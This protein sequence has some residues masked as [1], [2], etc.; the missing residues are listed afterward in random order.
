MSSAH[1]PPLPLHQA[2]FFFINYFGIL[3]SS[4]SIKKSFPMQN[5]TLFPLMPAIFS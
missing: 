4:E 2:N 1:S 3:R 5:L